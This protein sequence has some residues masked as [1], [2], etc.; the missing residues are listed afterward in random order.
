[1]DE[2]LRLHR[3]GDLAG[4]EALYR[5]ILGRRP[6]EEQAI[7]LL[8]VLTLQRGDAA[9]ALELMGRAMALRPGDPLFLANAA[10]AYRALGRL[11]EAI[12]CCRAAL[13]LR[14]DFPEAANTLGLIFLAQGR[15]EAA[16]EPFREALRAWPDF[17]MGHNNLGNALRLLGDLEAALGHFQ[18]AVQLD[19]ALAMARSNL[20]QLL[21][22]RR[23]PHEA[24][25]HCREAVRRAPGLAESHS[26]LGNVLRELGRL[27]EAK[28]CYA[29]ALRLN[30][31]LP[32]V[33]NNMGQALEEEGKLSE[34]IAWYRRALGADPTSAR[35]HTHLAG[36][37]LERED[38]EGAAAEYRAALDHDPGSAE[39]HAGLGALHQDRGRYAEAEASL[40]EA[41]RLKPD[42]A[43][44][45][46]QLGTLRLEL[47]DAAEALA[48][49]R[50]AFRRDPRCTGALYQIAILLR[51]ELPEADRAALEQLMAS[52][53][54]SDPK[55]TCLHFGLAQVLDARGDYEGAAEHLRRAN[56]LQAA[57]W[58][59]RGEGYDPE[60]HA[61]F[62]SGIIAACTPDFF[63][64]GRGWGLETQRPVFI[65]GL[66]RSGTTLV[67][68]I[69]ASHSQ[70]FG[71]GE[72]AFARDDFLGL[73]GAGGD[74]GRAIEAL[75]QLEGEAIRRVAREH[76][77]KLGALD[78]AA[79]RVTDKM[80]DNYR[81]LG[82]LAALFP[83]AKFIHCR[84]DLRDVAVSC[85]ITSFRQIR[86]ANDPEHIATRFRDYQRLMEH[87]SRVLPVPVCEV[88]YE[89]TV[90]DLEGVARRLIAWCGLEWEPGCLAFHA[91][92]RP[93]HTASVSQVRQPI[94]TRSVARWKHYEAALGPL[95]TALGPDVIEGGQ[96]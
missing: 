47:G 55:R 56:A 85:W 50:E 22:E 51:G 90:A 8:G 42:L 29:E 36:A 38:Y 73:A 83:K 52:P 66:P 28:S 92:K 18:R 26:N 75:G 17:A 68:Q 34:A 77:D 80:P 31:G 89:E 74:E 54:L 69:L 30:P 19:P 24:L 33:V 78:A 93:V 48:G 62:V 76:L 14:P 87:W 91:T 1:L 84:R 57:A 7:H 65:F 23:Q 15:A 39:A 96:P 70:V 64:R 5:A 49:F 13:R 88:D 20:G 72:L 95:F 32:M 81:Y 63:A 21:L 61:R 35:F 59:L 16:V 27:D 2:A 86:W 67:E 41:V 46:L 12:E 82:L 25:E 4:A 45:H 6:W 79:A 11:G 40:G 53:D 60:L 94:Y 10:E 43:A 3:A 37:L 44:A 58:R 9:G 71:A